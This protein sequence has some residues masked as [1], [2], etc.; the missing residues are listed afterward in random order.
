MR[1]VVLVIVGAGLGLVGGRVLSRVLDS[2]LWGISSIDPWAFVGATGVM[3]AAGS[4]ACL[5][6]ALRAA[7]V[8]PVT[9][10]RAE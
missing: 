6:P 2:L 8:D 1:G 7:R 10:L 9:V 4:A 5:L 3:L